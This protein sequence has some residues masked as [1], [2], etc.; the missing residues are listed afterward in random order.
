LNP[1]EG[2]KIPAFKNAY[3]A[4]AIADRELDKLGK[5]LLHIANVPDFQTLSHRVNLT[6]D[7]AAL[8][9][10]CIELETGGQEHTTDVN[11]DLI[12]DIDGLTDSVDLKFHVQ[13]FDVA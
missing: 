8:P 6:S 4:E 10:S 11:V 7:G 2:L 3:S 1:K 9:N 13:L 5:Y 12:S